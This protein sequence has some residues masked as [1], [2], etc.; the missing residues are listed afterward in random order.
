MILSIQYQHL[1]VF[2]SSKVLQK[3]RH[4]GLSCGLDLPEIVRKNKVVRQN[5][6]NI[7]PRHFHLIQKKRQKEVK[8][9]VMSKDIETETELKLKMKKTRSNDKGTH[10]L[11]LGDDI[12]WVRDLLRLQTKDMILEVIS[13]VLIVHQNYGIVV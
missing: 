11:D 2:L 4:I 6:G 10:R 9:M 8:M 3:T 12:R 7:V 1:S 13:Q 5:F